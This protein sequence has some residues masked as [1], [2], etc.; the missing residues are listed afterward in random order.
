[1]L[2][3]LMKTLAPIWYERRQRAQQCL[4]AMASDNQPAPHRERVRLAPQRDGWRTYVDG[5]TTPAFTSYTDALRAER[6]MTATRAADNFVRRY[7][8]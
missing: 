4:A 3:S 6:R 7:R 5:I 1:M 8:G 2:D